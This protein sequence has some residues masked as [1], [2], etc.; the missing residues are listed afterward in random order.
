MISLDLF[1]RIPL[2]VLQTPHEGHRVVANKH[3]VV[4][5]G[6]ALFL[7]RGRYLIP[8]YNS[9]ER[10]VKAIIPKLYP[11]AESI[12]IPAAFVKEGG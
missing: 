7:K 8:Q 6:A 3:W 1:E 12:F 4:L 10:V 9:D 5:N 11:E 2:D